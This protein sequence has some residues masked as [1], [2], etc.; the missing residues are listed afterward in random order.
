MNRKQRR[1]HERRQRKRKAPDAEKVTL[2]ESVSDHA[3]IMV[4]NPPWTPFRRCA[5]AERG[6]AERW[7]NSRYT[8]AL[9]G[10]EDTPTPEGWPGVVHL[11]FRHNAN[12]AITDFRD[13]QRIKSE[14]VH[15]EAMALQIFPGESQLV[16]LCNQYHLWVMVPESWPNVPEGFDWRAAWLPIGF[17]GGRNVSEN[18]PPGGRQRT[19]E[20]DRKP[21][22]E[23]EE[24]VKNAVRLR[25]AEG[26]E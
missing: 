13:M 9:Y 19:F 20:E 18:P 16:D 17:M 8:V 2:T 24:H 22:P 10:P 15:P 11:S 1:Q 25:D 4:E 14:M 12:I 6:G 3:T 26:E 5:E 21:T 23:E 7:E